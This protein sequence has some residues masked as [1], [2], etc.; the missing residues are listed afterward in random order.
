MFYGID[1]LP[2]HPISPFL[3]SWSQ[4]WWCSSASGESS[5]VHPEKIKI[6]Y[7]F[8]FN[9]RPSCFSSLFKVAYCVQIITSI[10]WWDS[11][12]E[13]LDHESSV[14]ATRPE[15]YPLVI[16]SIHVQKGM[17][18]Q[19]AFTVPSWPPLRGPKFESRPL[20]LMCYLW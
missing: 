2:V 7:L 9:A 13:T 10:Q 20:L 3:E 14:V 16:V 8:N 4:E 18:N 19:Y 6:E 12:L 11:N 17:A 5:T 1:N 15:C